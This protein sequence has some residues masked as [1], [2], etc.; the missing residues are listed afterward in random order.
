MKHADALSWSYIELTT[1][2]GD[3]E[4]FEV[5]EFLTPED[6]DDPRFGEIALRFVML[7]AGS[8]DGRPPLLFLSGGPGESAIEMLRHTAFRIHFRKASANRDLILLDQRGIG[9]SERILPKEYAKHT[10][11]DLVDPD[12]AYSMVY[13][14]AARCRQELKPAFRPSCYTPTQSARDI[15]VLADALRLDRIDIWAHSYG[16]HLTMA[17]L[18]LIPERIGHVTLCGFEGPDQT[19]KLPSRVTAQLGRLAEHFATRDEWPDMLGDMALVHG[20]LAEAP[21]T[22][23][24]A[25]G[26]E[27]QVGLFGLQWLVSS[28]IGLSGRFR[29]LPALYKSLRNGETAELERAASGFVKMLDRRPP[30]F[31]LNDSAS[32]ATKKRL[33][34]IAEESKTCLLA[35]A[36]NFPFPKI[37]EAWG[38]IDLGDAFRAPLECDHTM[39]IVTGSL[40]GFTPTENAR[41]SLDVLPNAT[42]EELPGLAHDDLLTAITP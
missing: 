3:G 1:R 24:V 11:Y 27:I 23:R 40:D 21:L 19:F 37:R 26:E 10:P 13:E 32:G 22:V 31:Y 14:Q 33:G 16:T 20:R 18:K 4:W 41:Q 15:A 17:A 36:I 29:R 25:S 2:E 9:R 42:L 8:P 5:G 28:W 35:N 6:H 30:A 7:R 34:R 12:E 38:Q 39:R